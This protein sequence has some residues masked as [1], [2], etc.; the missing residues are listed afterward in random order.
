[1]MDTKA[2]DTTCDCVDV[3]LG[4]LYMIYFLLDCIYP[5]RRSIIKNTAKAPRDEGGDSRLTIR[6]DG[7]D[8][9]KMSSLHVP[10]LFWDEM[11]GCLEIWKGCKGVCMVSCIHQSKI[12]WPASSFIGP[13]EMFTMNKDL[14]LKVCLM[15]LAGLSGDSSYSCV[16]DNKA[17]AV[18]VSGR[19]CGLNSCCR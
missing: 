15:K 3:R 7:L 16:T 18:L 11:K 8:L 12:C 10:L 4:V 13:K 1:M 2:V 6:W 14:M 17:D 5:L 9:G 19:S